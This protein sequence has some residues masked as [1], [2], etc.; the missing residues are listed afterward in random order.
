MHSQCLQCLEQC[1]RAM[2]HINTVQCA[3]YLGNLR[4]I[5]SS[6]FFISVASLPHNR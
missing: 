1:I 3:M 5:S 2:D 6:Y 4:P